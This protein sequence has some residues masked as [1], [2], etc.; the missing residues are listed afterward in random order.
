MKRK[1][2]FRGDLDRAHHAS[3]LCGSIMLTASRSKNLKKLLAN[4]LKGIDKELESGDME[5]R[6]P[7]AA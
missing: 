3:I 7:T 6:E 2:L 1:P 4:L 5:E